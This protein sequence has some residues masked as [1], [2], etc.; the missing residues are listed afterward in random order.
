MR[1]VKGVR[2]AFA[3]SVET[4]IHVTNAKE[5]GRRVNPYRLPPPP[6]KIPG[7]QSFPHNGNSASTPAVNVTIAR[8]TYPTNTP[9]AI[10]CGYCE[11]VACCH[12]VCKGCE[13]SFCGFCRNEDKCYECEVGR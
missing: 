1:F 2:K 7:Y 12:A 5:G 10:T 9:S 4:K 13:K 8:R 11:R 6:P 3:G